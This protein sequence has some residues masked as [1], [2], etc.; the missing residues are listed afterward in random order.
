MNPTH[1]DR[2][3]RSLAEVPAPATSRV[4]LIEDQHLF[5]DVLCTVL[6]RAKFEVVSAC[7]NTAEG[8]EA[9]EFYEPDLVLLDLQGGRAGLDC[10]KE[11]LRSISTI[12]LVALSERDDRTTVRRA[13]AAGFA[14]YLT[15]NYSSGSF[16]EALKAIVEGKAVFQ[17]RVVP[18]PRPSTGPDKAA[19]LWAC[20]LTQRERQVLERIALGDTSQCIAADFSLSVNTVRS[21][22]QAILTKLQ[23]HSRLE[24]AA[25]ALECG[26]AEPNRSVVDDSPTAQRNWG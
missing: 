17:H 22:V 5:A 1:T 2:I 21:H 11:I 4:V 10:G 26:L 19:A 12:K 23:V 15:K 13:M 16:V 7:S 9:I 6:E 18:P 3:Q 8:L 20:Q 25:F 24:A 14:G